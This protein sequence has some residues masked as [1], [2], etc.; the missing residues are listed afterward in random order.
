V[1]ENHQ[2]KARHGIR[3]IPLQAACSQE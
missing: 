1:D 2:L 3:T